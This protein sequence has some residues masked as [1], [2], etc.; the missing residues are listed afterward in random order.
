MQELLIA[1]S[2]IVRRICGKYDLV[3]EVPQSYSLK[4][5]GH[6]LAVQVHVSVFTPAMSMAPV[7]V[8]VNIDLSFRRYI[9]PTQ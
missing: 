3:M 5:C 8:S 7:S 1:M 2:V 9:L 4:F 6:L